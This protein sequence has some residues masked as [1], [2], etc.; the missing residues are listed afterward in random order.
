M[1]TAFQSL[2]FQNNAFQIEGYYIPVVGWVPIYDGQTPAWGT[3]STV[4]SAGWTSISDGQVP[5]WGVTPTVQSPGWAD[6]STPDT[7]NWQDIVNS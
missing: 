2:G 7:P 5:G 4:Q 3:I 1:T 6:I